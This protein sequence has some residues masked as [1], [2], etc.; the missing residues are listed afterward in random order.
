V[1]SGIEIAVFSLELVLVQ[2]W[3]V[4]AGLDIVTSTAFD[5]I[6]AGA[7]TIVGFALSKSAALCSSNIARAWDAAEIVLFFESVETVKAL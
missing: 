3:K 4:P 1:L 5:V 2:C 7:L 6:F